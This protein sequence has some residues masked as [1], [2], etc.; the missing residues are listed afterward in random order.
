[1]MISVA[2]C[3]YNGERYIEALLASIF[4]QTRKPDEI[5]ICDDQ[6]TDGTVEKIR[7]LV[8]KADIACD[9]IVNEKNLGFA[10]NFQKCISL[11]KGDVIFLCDQDDVWKASK[12]EELSAIMERQ[13]QILSIT[14]NFHLI[15]TKGERIRLKKAGDNPFFAMRRSEIDR[16]EGDLYKVSLRT[17]RCRNIAPGCTQ[18]IRVSIV[19]DFLSLNGNGVHD[20][21]LNLIAGIHDGLYYYDRPLTEYRYHEHQ[22]IGLPRYVMSK[23]YAGVAGCVKE[24]AHLFKKF[25]ALLFFRKGDRGLH[26][27]TVDN[28]FTEYA[29]S[30]GMSP[31]LRDQYNQWLKMASNRAVLYNKGKRSK[32]IKAFFLQGRYNKHFSYK[33][34]LYGSI[35]MRL[36]D[37]LVLI[38]R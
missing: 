30:V 7:E 19:K 13:P 9:L 20:H 29:R 27:F 8:A 37:V 12:I 23:H 26:T 31:E 25:I 10:R 35:K 18:A 1:M 17:I 4:S 24:Y 34:A 14:T 21:E 5:V 2:L 15:D 28:K 3:T 36:M 32:R 16:K 33:Y 11:C 22:A 6:S 38:K